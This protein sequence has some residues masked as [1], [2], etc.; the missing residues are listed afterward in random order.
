[1][2]LTGVPLSQALSASSQAF[3]HTCNAASQLTVKCIATDFI[4][5]SSGAD[6]RRLN[7]D[8]EYRVEDTNPGFTVPGT[9]FSMHPCYMHTIVKRRQLQL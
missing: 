1:M 9:R 2:R 5:Q 4:E 6:E 8:V 3:V 7:R